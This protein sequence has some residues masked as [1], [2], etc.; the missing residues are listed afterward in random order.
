MSEPLADHVYGIVM[1]GTP[2]TSCRSCGALIVWGLT[3]KDSRAPFDHPETE[4]GWVNHWVTCKRP[5]ERR[6]KGAGP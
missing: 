1:P 3:K 4:H 6:R 5:P 2:I